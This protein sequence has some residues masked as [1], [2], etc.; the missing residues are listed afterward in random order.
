MQSILWTGA[1]VKRLL[2]MLLTSAKLEDDWA[3]QT[4]C[5]FIHNNRDPE[6]SLLAFFPF[7]LESKFFELKIIEKQKRSRSYCV[8]EQEIKLAS[9]QLGFNT[10]EIKIE[11]HSNQSQI[12]SWQLVLFHFNCFWIRFELRHCCCCCC[13]FVKDSR[14]DEDAKQL[15]MMS[16]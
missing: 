7:P 5:N 14:Y 1:E 12:Q 16:F 15:P 11:W 9:E 8:T 2:L 10:N 6:K 13:F 4:S 3:E